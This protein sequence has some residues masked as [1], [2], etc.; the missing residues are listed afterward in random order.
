MLANSDR[1]KGYESNTAQ[2]DGAPGPDPA[3]FSLHSPFAA[4][5]A[6]IRR[7]LGEASA[8]VRNFPRPRQDLCH[9]TLSSSS[10]ATRVN[11]SVVFLVHSLFARRHGGQARVSIYPRGLSTR[12]G[13]GH[14]GNDVASD[15]AASHFG[16]QFG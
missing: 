11:T 14:L 9:R 7:Y 1:A 13:R 3:G 8:S 4:G 12:A 2:A 10:A 16:D 5:E 6:R 15:V